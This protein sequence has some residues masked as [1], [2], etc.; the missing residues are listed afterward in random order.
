MSAILDLPT[1]LVEALRGFDFVGKP[2]W[3]LSAGLTHVKVELTF[4]LRELDDQPIDQPARAVRKP[5][6]RGK[7]RGQRQ[8]QRQPAIQQQP[9]PRE[10]APP[11]IETSPA[12]PPATIS[13]QRPATTKTLAPALTSIIQ[14]PLS[15]ATIQK[16]SRRSEPV[17]TSSPIA[18]QLEPMTISPEEPADLN[19]AFSDTSA[20]FDPDTSPMWC[21]KKLTTEKLDNYDFKKLFRHYDSPPECRFVQAQRKPRPNSDDID[22]PTYFVKLAGDPGYCVMKGP[23]S[24]HHVEQWWN[25]IDREAAMS[26]P[27]SHP[28]LLGEINKIYNFAKEGGV[29]RITPPRRQQP[30]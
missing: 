26:R 22:L 16:Q 1:I 24:R 7:K 14:R 8:R 12:P 30:P 18:I 21:D 9:P 2:L 13:F 4:K 10:T 6:A 23:H 25:F 17:L 20:T 3:R 29:M 27:E 15:P 19:V 28:Y 11:T 5:A